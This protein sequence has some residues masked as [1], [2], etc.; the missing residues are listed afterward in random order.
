M[1][2]FTEEQIKRYSRHIILPEVGG[3]GQERINHASVLIVGA[4]GLGCPAAVYLA[5]AG[6]GKIGMVDMDKVEL[7]NLQ[8]Q[9]LH[10]VDDI[11]T[12]KTTS[13]KKKLQQLNP[14]VEVVEYSTKLT[15]GNIQ[16]IIE[17]YDV[18][19]DGCDNFPTRYL[20]NDAAVLSNKVVAHGAVLRFE[21]QATT[22]V[23]HDGPCYRCLYREPPPPGTVPTCQEAGVLGVLPGVIGVLQATEVLKHVLG[24]GRLLKGRLLLFNALEMEFRE[25]KIPKDPQCPV[26]GKKPT[27]TR[28][29]DYEEFCIRGGGDEGK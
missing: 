20:V 16:D 22:I 8:R 23:P 17:D 1:S 6:V 25:V 10:T 5:A 14:D 28:L 9:I 3:A 2:G 4:G 7:S 19:V 15:S 21:G 27:I 29:I 26:C 12:E 11:G 13:A 18:I 24:K